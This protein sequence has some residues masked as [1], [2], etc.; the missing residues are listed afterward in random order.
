MVKEIKWLEECQMPSK[1]ITKLLMTPL[2]LCMMI[3]SDKFRLQSDSSKMAV[4]GTLFQFQQG[5][6]VFIGYYSKRFSQTGQ[7]MASKSYI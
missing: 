4:G 6:W 2:V 1:H 5:Q 3:T 7:I